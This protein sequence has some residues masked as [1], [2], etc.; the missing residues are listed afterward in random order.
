MFGKGDGIVR[1]S[2]TMLCF[3]PEN[4]VSIARITHTI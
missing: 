4:V 1:D 2:E 3:A